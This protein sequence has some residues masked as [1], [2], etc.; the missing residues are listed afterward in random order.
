MGDKVRFRDNEHDDWSYGTVTTTGP[1]VKFRGKSTPR[2]DSTGTV[3]E[4]EIW[5]FVEKVEPEVWIA[6]TI[7][8]GAYSV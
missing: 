5:R 8:R 7:R 1:V 4:L 6:S 2:A 3:V